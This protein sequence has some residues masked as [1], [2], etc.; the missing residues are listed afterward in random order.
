MAADSVRKGDLVPYN[1]VLFNHEEAQKLVANDQ[2]RLKLED[3]AVKQDARATLQDD[4]INLLRNELES[5]RGYTL[6]KYGYFLLGVLGGTVLMYY[7]TKAA[8]NL[9]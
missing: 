4:R 1:G 7:G 9:K 2:K 3:L 5:Q 6:G 8:G